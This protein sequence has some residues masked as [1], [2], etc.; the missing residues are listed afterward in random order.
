MQSGARGIGARGRDAHAGSGG[1]PSSG[2][3]APAADS[4][5]DVVVIEVENA[6]SLPFALALAVRPYDVRSPARVQ[7]GAPGGPAAGRRGRRRSAPR[8]TVAVAV[9]A[10]DDGESA[11]PLVSGEAAEDGPSVRS[12][13]G[14]AQMAVLLRWPTGPRSASWPPSRCPTDAP[15][16]RPTS[17]RFPRGER[18]PR[19]GGPDRSRTASRAPRPACRRGDRRRP[20]PAPGPVPGTARPCSPPVGETAGCWGAAPA[21]AQWGFVA[22][23][24][25]LAGSIRRIQ[26]MGGRTVGLD[27]H[28]RHR[29]S[30]RRPGRAVAAHPTSSCSRTWRCRWC[31]PPTDRANRFS[32]ATQGPGAPGSAPCRPSSRPPRPCRPVRQGRLV[33]PIRVAGRRRGAGRRGPGPGGR[34]ARM[35]LRCAPTSTGRSP[36]SGRPTRP[37]H[38]PLGPIGCRR[39]DQWGSLVACAP[40]LLAPDDLD[41]RHPRPRAG[42]TRPARRWS[43]AC[44]TGASAR[45]SLRSRGWSSRRGDTDEAWARLGW[46]LDS[47]TP[48]WTWPDVVHPRG[49]EVAG[50]S[51]SLAATPDSSGCP[52]DAGTRAAIVDAAGHTRLGL[53]MCSV[54]A[55]GLAGPEHRGAI[56]D[57]QWDAY[58]TGCVARR[59]PGAA[60]G[61]S[62]LTSIR[63]RSRHRARSR[64]GLVEHRTREALLRPVQAGDR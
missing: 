40:R 53:A 59:S 34:G 60:P 35:L 4:D 8:P 52:A 10:T 42:S 43:P 51:H 39:R 33:V 5:A 1:T 27:G 47:A 17:P 2:S 61:S 11:V 63:P 12:R 56:A 20:A 50:D 6:S 30:P 38:F 28:G 36:S 62:C 18:G 15:H 24:G 32:P 3:T 31:G 19:V 45:R 26:G 54:S 21:L 25:E 29:R 48:H 64:P 37:V 49:A 23:A 44:S 41:H 16:P 14:R 13:A 57:R 9:S 58:P 22:E 55:N 46:L 7:R